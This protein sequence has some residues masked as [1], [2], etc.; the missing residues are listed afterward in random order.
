MVI[1]DEIKHKPYFDLL[2]AG[3][4]R[5]AID[6]SQYAD[7]VVIIQVFGTWCPNSFDQTRFLVDWYKSKNEDV[8]V[9]ASTYEPNYSKEYGLKRIADYKSNLGIPYDV[10]L[11]GQLSKAQAAFSF[12]FIERCRGRI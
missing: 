7:K 11:G 12:P 4:G 8:E 9:V 10:Y 5:N 2:G 3:S 6:V 1:I